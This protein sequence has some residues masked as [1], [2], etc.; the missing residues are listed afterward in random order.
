MLTVWLAARSILCSLGIWQEDIA[1]AE[2]LTTDQFI[3]A[4]INIFTNGLLLLIWSSC[5]TLY[6]IACLTLLRLDEL[7]LGQKILLGFGIGLVEMCLVTFILGWLGWL[8]QSIMIGLIIIMALF[9]LFMLRNHL[10]NIFTFSKFVS[11]EK[12]IWL[13]ALL[14]PI[15][16]LAFMASM[17]PSGI[18]WHDD[19]KGYDV[20]EYHL[21]LPKEYTQM[22]QITERPHNVFSYMPENM[23]MLYLV[24]ML[25]KSDHIEGMYLG[26][27]LNWL[28]AVCL[29]VAVFQFTC[30]WSRTGAIIATLAIA[31]PQLFFVSTIA[32]VE[33]LMLLM[34]T[35]GLG[36]AFKMTSCLD[37]QRWTYALLS[38]I[39][40]GA[41]CGTKYTALVMAAPIVAIVVLMITKWH[42][43]TFGIFLFALCLTFSPWLIK[44]AILTG[45]PVFPLAAK[46]LGQHH[47]SDEQVDRWNQSV[48]AKLSDEEI[49]KGIIYSKIKKL[50]QQ[51]LLPKYYGGVCIIAGLI[52]L[53]ARKAISQRVVMILLLGFCIQLLFWTGFTHLQSRF[54]LFI[55]IP[56]A[57][58][59]AMLWSHIQSFILKKALVAITIVFTTFHLLICVDAYAT[60]TKLPTSQYG[61][62]PLVFRDEIIAAAYPFSD[63][64][65][66]QLNKK[67][68]FV[69]EAR[70]FYTLCDVVY[71]T[72]YDH[73]ELNE[74]LASEEIVANVIR[75]LN[76]EG[77]THMYVDWNEVNRLHKN[78]NFAPA[79]TPDA[80]KKLEQAGLRLI[81]RQT[82]A[83]YPIELYEVK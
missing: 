53:V 41:A 26:K 16:S 72:V 48:Q 76:D 39:F 67:C 30:Q 8:S 45:N 19:G 21:Q 36:C 61:F 59:I 38:G 33:T 65:E 13:T 24:A 62:F 29:L 77:I 34:F 12:S 14:I 57:F 43:Q 81:E 10:K 83:R 27:I 68:L 3:L 80:I 60:S 23:E 79:I 49:E 44:N 22:G 5:L 55:L 1:G 40:I 63:P 25:I 37:E 51:L 18:L 50:L 46:T 17:L 78:Y 82:L 28:L 6:G 47:W 58:L 4:I 52:L 73:C 11:S 20:L 9:G 75:W 15:A 74:R 35:L 2:S 71:H 66:I 56:L 64:L 32:Y 42:W 54:L 31:G 7:P 70:P 69:G